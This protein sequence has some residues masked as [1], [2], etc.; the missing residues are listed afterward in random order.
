MAARAVFGEH[1]F[2]ALKHA[3]IFG[4]IVAAAGRIL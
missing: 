4:Q 1:D 3:L 2:A